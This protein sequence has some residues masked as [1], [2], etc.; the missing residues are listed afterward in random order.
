MNQF[1][2]R[3]TYKYLKPWF[4]SSDDP[5]RIKAPY[6]ISFIFLFLTVIS[7][8]IHL[9]IR[10]WQFGRIVELW[11][12]GKGENLT[13]IA[14]IARLDI[15]LVPLIAVLVG[16]AGLFIGLYNWGK[17]RKNIPSISEST[18]EGTENDDG[19]FVL[20]EV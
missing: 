12:D 9:V 1:L 7:I 8:I 2:K 10:T 6:V 3:I 13:E 18:Y 15:T 16:S 19:E 11:R 5:D 14:D 17:S 20:N 4:F